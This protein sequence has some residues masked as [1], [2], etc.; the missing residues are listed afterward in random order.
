MLH[1]NFGRYRDNDNVGSEQIV[2]I[3][4]ESSTM[5]IPDVTSPSNLTALS[6]ALSLTNTALRESEEHLHSHPD[7]ISLLDVKNDLLLSYL[8]NLVFLI[9]LKLRTL[10]SSEDGTQDLHNSVVQKLIEARIYLE[11]G[12]RPLEGKMKYQIDQVLRAAEQDKLLR[13][14]N[15]KT[16]QQKA[17]VNGTADSSSDMDSDQDD[18]TIPETAVPQQSLSQGVSGPRIEQQ[19]A[20]KSIP[21]RTTPSSRTSSSKDAIYRA[22]RITPTTMP[23]DPDRRTRE[24]RR[25]KSQLLTEYIDEE[26]SSAPH[27]QPSIGSNNT[28]LD[29]G[30]GGMSQRD[31]EKERERT[32]YEEKHFTRLPGESKAERRKARLRGEKDRRDMFGGEDWTGL[33]GLGDRVSRSVSGRGDG[34]G[35]LKRREKR[36]ERAT[37][38][39]PRGDGMGE[40][41]EKRRRILEGREAKRKRR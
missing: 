8:Q 38:D 31:R 6:D 14:G 9:L 19:M 26:L 10:S 11:R 18:F 36:R 32:E 23:S 21:S 40:G 22:P 15:Q 12:I 24:P 1:Q 27:A 34:D 28:I 29:Y 37:E 7:G 25:Q 33:G 30:R 35:V 20:Q 17:S 3:Q 16:S 2:P 13:Q 5:T 4:R 41:F 39:G